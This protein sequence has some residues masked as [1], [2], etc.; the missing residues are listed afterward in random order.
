MRFRD[1]SLQQFGRLLA[2]FPIG[3]RGQFTYWACLCDCGCTAVVRVYNL[4]SGHTQSCGCF[5]R[6]MSAIWAKARFTGKCGQ[7]S[8][9]FKHGHTIDIAGQSLTYRTWRNVIQRCT[10]PNDPKWKHYGGA[11]PPVKIDPQWL[12]EYGFK[13]FLADLGE[14]PSS[15]YSL[16]RFLD[17]GN[18]EPSNVEWATRAQQESEA[19]GKRTMLRFRTWKDQQAQ[20]EILAVAAA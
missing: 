10:N 19:R 12:G 4:L 1:I 2:S 16:S 6:E 8:P 9:S 7:D 20:Q 13:A 5:L 3:M 14:R 11:N 17:S 15:K 18:Y